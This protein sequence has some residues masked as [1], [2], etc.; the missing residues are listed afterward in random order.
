MSIS[1]ILD[2]AQEFLHD[3]G[4]IWPRVELLN[5][6]NDGYRQLLAQ[7]HAVVR[8][9]QL[10]VPGRTAWS[11]TQEWEDRHG[12]GTWRK[13]TFSVRSVSLE[14]TYRWESQTLEGISPEASVDS[15]TQLWELAF[16]GSVDQHTRLVLSKQHERPLK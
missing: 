2:K 4:A 9:F 1:D 10:D 5:W 16:A 14:C 12:E 15:I 13:F 7:S 11:S 6:A 8:P 3:D